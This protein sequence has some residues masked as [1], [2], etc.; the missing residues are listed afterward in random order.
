MEKVQM[1]QLFNLV[2]VIAFY[3]DRNLKVVISM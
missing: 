1:L 3:F 2:H